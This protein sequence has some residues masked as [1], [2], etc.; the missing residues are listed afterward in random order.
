MRAGLI[1]LAA[2]RVGGR[3]VLAND[4]F[5]APK[6]NLL[7]PGSPVFLEGKYTSRGKWMDGWE[8]RRRRTPG[9]DWCIVRL[10]VP[11][12]ARAVTVDTRH[13]RGNHPEAC[14]LDAAALAGKDDTITR[15]RGGGA[16]A[17]TTLLPRTPLASDSLNEFP[18]TGESRITH[19][20]LNIYPD[21]GVARLR[22]WG[23]ARP[24]WAALERK[25]G[26]LDLAALRNGGTPLA[27]SDQFFSD[28][29]NL[30]MPGSPEDMSDGWETRRR[31]G[32][33]HDWVILRLGARGTID[34]VR[35]DTTH[36]K[37]NFPES[38][39]L[40]GCDLPE[41]DVNA[42]PDEGAPWRELVPR[43]KLKADAQHRFR[44]VGRSGPVTHVR[45][46]IYPDGGV[47]RLRLYGRRV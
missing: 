38:C 36:F 43:T 30:L 5:F 19:V 1:D 35:V 24:D 31:R 2:A 32:P 17:W 39:R 20:R 34:A 37:G 29:L 23:E 41:L 16:A 28:P 8:T 27:A 13:F 11:G 21:G 47:A 4:E 40:E 9:S 18:V 7:K 46:S 10:G 15:R 12:V 3:A 45:F 33:G 14:S 44:A 42:V 6:S 26:H 22:V 25:K